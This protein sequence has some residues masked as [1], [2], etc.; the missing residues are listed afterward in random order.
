MLGSRTPLIACAIA[1]AMFAVGAVHAAAALAPPMDTSFGASLSGLNPYTFEPLNRG[2][3]VAP[4]GSFVI[5]GARRVKWRGERGHEMDRWAIKRFKKNGSTDRRFGSRGTTLLKFR[6]DRSSYPHDN[7]AQAAA[8]QSDGKLLVAGSIDVAT[9]GDF[10]R[11]QDGEDEELPYGDVTNYVMAIARFT[12][13][14]KLDKSFGNGGVRTIRT[15]PAHRPWGP[16]QDDEFVAAIQQLPNKKIVVTADHNT[17]AFTGGAQRGGVYR[18]TK[19]GAVDHSFGTGGAVR[20]TGGPGKNDAFQLASSAIDATGRIVLVGSIYKDDKE[21]WGVI[22]VQPNGSLDKTFGDAGRAVFA[23]G[24][25][26]DQNAPIHLPHRARSIAIAA[27]G[28]LLVS[29]DLPAL[30][31]ANLSRPGALRLTTDGAVDNTFGENGVAAASTPSGSTSGGYSLTLTADGKIALAGLIQL[32]P[33]EREDNQDWS[34]I[35]AR[36]TV[37][38]ARD[39][40]WGTDGLVQ[41]AGSGVSV[42][43]SRIQLARQQDQLLLA[44]CR[45]KQGKKLQTAE[46]FRLLP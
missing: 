34:G 45:T 13:R 15:T 37:E 30:G 43:G 42:C 46:V 10:N 16:A 17:H 44:G 24:P 2:F 14:G 28:K 32:P 7:Y 21:S 23:A 39:A 38:G 18:L 29:G 41:L 20:I 5:A 27:D 31:N 19:N 9:L 3:A 8:F 4:D 33:L 6:S 40:T 35:V 25:L 1:F 26:A 11:A 12:K 22:R 36:F